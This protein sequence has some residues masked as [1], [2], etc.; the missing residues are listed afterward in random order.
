MIQVQPQCPQCGSWDVKRGRNDWN[1]CQNCGVWFNTET[2]EH[3]W[4]LFG[5]PE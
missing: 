1:R 2:G 4:R 3:Q 5:T